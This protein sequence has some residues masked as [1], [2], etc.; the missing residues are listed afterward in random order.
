[1]SFYQRI[2][3]SI[4][5]SPIYIDSNHN[6]WPITRLHIVLKRKM[7]W[8]HWYILLPPTQV[9][10]K[11]LILKFDVRWH[12]RAQ[13]TCPRT[14]ISSGG[15]KIWR[16]LGH[17]SVSHIEE[18]Y[19]VKVSNLEKKTLTS[20]YFKF[21]LATCI[22]SLSYTFVWETLSYYLFFPHVLPP[23]DR[24]IDTRAYISARLDQFS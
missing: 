19:D 11:P 12:I 15:P 23:L 3:Q 7:Y 22:V 8:L 1:M 17:I 16:K 10:S 2:K 24:P 14:N 20:N 9:N 5:L 18:Q 6:W 4:S 21:N 13:T